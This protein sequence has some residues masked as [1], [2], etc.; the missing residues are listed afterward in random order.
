MGSPTPTV[1]AAE[2]RRQD[3][4]LIRAAIVGGLVFYHTACIFAPIG[5]YVADEPPNFLMTGFVLFAQLWGMPLL[6]VVAGSGIWHS[7]GT[8]TPARFARERLS[9]LLVP[10]VTGMLLI[11][12]P[13]LYYSMLADG[14]DPG[15][16]WEFLGRFFDV[17]PVASFPLFVVGAEPDRL[18]DLAHLWFLYYLFAWSLLLLPVLLWLRGSGQWLTDWLVARCE[19]PWGLLL[20]ALPVALVEAAFGTWGPGGWNGYAYLAFLVYGFLFAADRRLR[21][22]VQRRWK[23]AMAVGLAILPLVAA[24]A[25]FDLGGTSWVVGLDYDPWSILW[26]LLKATAGWA[27]TV[28]VFGLVSSL[29]RRRPRAEGALATGSGR[30]RAAAGYTREA[31]LPFYVLHQ[32]PIV[33]IGFYVIQW[34]VNFLLKYLVISL[35]ALVV[36]LAAYDLLVRRSS[37]TRVLFGMPARPRALVDEPVRVPAGGA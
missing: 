10:L 16:Y 1:R 12:P 37:V 11:V 8:R 14:E 17:R 15:S 3:L 2:R 22:A 27:L 35:A 34:P 25:A 30:G 36:T 31:V 33:L 24:I 19:G 26:R 29:M 18:F 7:L 9:R 28:G 23:Q 13:Q 4:D 5:F 21:A 32:T 20:M 6:F